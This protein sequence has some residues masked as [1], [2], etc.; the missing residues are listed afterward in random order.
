MLVLG[1]YHEVGDLSLAQAVVVQLSLL[2]GENV[3]LESPDME[4]NLSNIEIF[5]INPAKIIT[6]V[7]SVQKVSLTAYL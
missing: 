3:F 1:T 2:V 5:S 7:L 4:K 6:F